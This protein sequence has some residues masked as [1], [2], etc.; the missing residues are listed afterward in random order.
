MA[1]GRRSCWR[2]IVS[3]VNACVH[4]IRAS[5]CCLASICVLL[6]IAAARLRW[7]RP[8][9]CGVLCCAMLFFAVW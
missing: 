2:G 1:V 3:F 6:L 5:T 8:L 4:M 7:G 9:D